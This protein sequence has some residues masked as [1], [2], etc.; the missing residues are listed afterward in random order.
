MFTGHLL[1]VVSFPFFVMFAA[2]P[3]APEGSGRGKRPADPTGSRRGADMRISVLY[4]TDHLLFGTFF[5]HR[6][7][8]QGRRRPGRAAL[9]GNGETIGQNKA[10]RRITFG[11]DTIAH[12]QEAEADTDTAADHPDL[13]C[14]RSA[15]LLIRADPLWRKRPAF[16]P[17]RPDLS[18]NI[19]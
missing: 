10:E 8:E 13:Q 18:G 15:F 16:R 6:Y 9:L 11:A 3:T 1:D 12:Q 5:C 2:L 17:N 4:V 19:P 14:L 7:A